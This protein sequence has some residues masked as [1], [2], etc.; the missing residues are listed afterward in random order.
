[1]RYSDEQLLD[2]IRNKY[3]AIGKTPTKEDIDSDP[4]MPSSSTYLS[5]FGGLSKVYELLGIKPNV[6]YNLSIEKLVKFAQDFYEQNGRSP[7][8]SDFDNTEGYPHSCFIRD[9]CNMTWNEF[10]TFANLPLFENGVNYKKNREAE[11]YVK[12]I[13]IKN[14]HKVEDLSLKS[15]NSPYSFI[16]DDKISISVKSSIP[17]LNNNRYRWHFKAGINSNKFKPDY[18][19]CLGYNENRIIE[20]MFVIPSDIIKVKQSLCIYTDAY[21]ESIYATYEMDTIEFL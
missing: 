7:S 5:R 21:N 18:Y 19:I 9:V 4:N 16:V 15:L 8:S 3:N 1:M 10:L 13:L 17:I 20:T 2:L 12:E 6:V 14:G 11:L